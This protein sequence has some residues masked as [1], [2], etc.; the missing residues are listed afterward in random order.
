MR[1]ENICLEKY[2]LSIFGSLVFRSLFDSVGPDHTAQQSDL[3]PHCLPHTYI[4][5][6]L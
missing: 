5:Q 3:G 6:I 2:F 4:I 1:C